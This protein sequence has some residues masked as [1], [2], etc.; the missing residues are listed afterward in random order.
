MKLS[1]GH[2]LLAVIAGACF[3]SFAH[4]ARAQAPESWNGGRV[5][6]LVD[7]A[8]AVRS[9]VAVDS[10]FQSYRGEAKGYVYFFIDRPDAEERTLVKAAQVAL[11]LFW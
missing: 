8:Q 4:D 9:S 6:E 3:A 5:L 1:L 7:Q 11:D 2:L 10:A